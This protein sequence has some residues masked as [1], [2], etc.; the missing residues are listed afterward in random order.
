MT[1]GSIHIIEWVVIWGVILL[2][3]ILDLVV[4]EKSNRGI[5]SKPHFWVVFWFALGLGFSFYLLHTRGEHQFIQYLTA[6]LIEESLS[7]DNMFTFSYIFSLFQIDFK[8]QRRILY[9]GILGAIVMRI[10]F[11]IAGIEIIRRFQIVMYIFGL[12]II[13]SALDMLKRA[14][15]SREE[16]RKQKLPFQSLLKK[17]RIDEEHRGNELIVKK[18]GKYFLTVSAMALIS[19]LIADIVFAID[20]VPVVLAIT[21]DRF[22][23]ITSNV[24]AVLGL[25]ALYSLIIQLLKKVYYMEYGLA[26]ILFFIGAKILISQWIHVSPL[27]SL[28]VVIGILSITFVFSALRKKKNNGE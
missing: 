25:R 21:Q 12:L 6:F 24:A 20:S 14:I 23:A 11:I 3:T 19:I 10:L 8:Y 2:A 26:L 17:L 22:V 13:Y 15:K 1:E 27:I 9:V 4:T 18:G 16:E 7:I 28:G 5:W